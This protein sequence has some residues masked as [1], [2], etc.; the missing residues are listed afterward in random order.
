MEKQRV[1]RANSLPGSVNGFIKL[2][3]TITGYSETE[4]LATGLP[5]FYYKLVSGILSEEFLDE[6]TTLY[7]KI[8]EENE[9]HPKKIAEELT[10]Q[11][12]E[13][14]KWGPVGRNIIQL[15]YLGQWNQLNGKWCIKNR[16]QCNDCNHETF[17]PSGEAYVEGLAWDALAAHPMAGKQVGFAAWSFPPPTKPGSTF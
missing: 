14:E 9:G 15:W 8:V 11:I 7:L 10:V 2:S 17:I 13:N 5:D 1:S 16:K 6:M 12:F 3:S 4:L